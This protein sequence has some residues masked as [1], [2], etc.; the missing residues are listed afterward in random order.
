MKIGA[1]VTNE[2]GVFLGHSGF[3]RSD[4]S[5]GYFSVIPANAG[6]Q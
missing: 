5:G 2:E 6:I 1:G 3:R 4:E